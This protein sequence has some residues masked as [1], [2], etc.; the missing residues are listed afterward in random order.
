MALTM[1][2]AEYA[3]SKSGTEKIKANLDGDIKNIKTALKGA[4][5]DALVKTFGRYWVGA[6]HD[7]F[8]KD[9]EA[10]INSIV[11]RCTKIQKFIDDALTNDYNNFI[12]NQSSFY[13]K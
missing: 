13:K 10:R 12:K 3:R 4:E 5:K 9:L 7:A 11:S 1:E 2:N 6:D 8:I